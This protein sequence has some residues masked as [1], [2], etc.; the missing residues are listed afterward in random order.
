V[1]LRDLVADAAGAGVQEHPD[2]ILL[3][4]ADFDEVVAARL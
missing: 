1:E 4:E 2:P 3:V